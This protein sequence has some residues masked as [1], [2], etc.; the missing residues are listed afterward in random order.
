MVLAVTVWG[1]VWPSLAAAATW[2]LLS[3]S[4][5]DSFQARNLDQF[6][7]DVEQATAGQLRIVVLADPARLDGRQIKQAVAAGRA[8]AGELLFSDL[9][10]EDAAFE[11]DS[12]PFLATDYYEALRLWDASRPVL[13]RMLEA[14]GVHA[15]FAVASPPRGLFATKNI[16]KMDDLRGLRL[17]DDN[18]FTRQLAIL[19][20]AVPTRVPGS[21][22]QAFAAGEIDAAIASLPDGV[23][24]QAWD[25]V[26][27]YYD[28]GVTLPKSVVVFNR[29]AFGSLDPE[30]QRAVLNAA[31]A[32]Q[33][34]GW[35]ASA[36][37]NNDAV[38]LMQAHG[39]SIAAP[40]PQLLA[41]MRKIGARMADEWERRSGSDAQR[42]L[43]AYRM[44]R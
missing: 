29:A 10:D 24:Q 21:M 30:V 8:P 12:I 35:K 1:Y 3:P 36:A 26:D 42:I 34:R 39:M 41:D 11:A 33:N 44:Q 37:A 31:V 22:V 25:V 23:A 9:R 40:D 17:L 38:D 5:P 43:R 13:G 7:N 20:E 28:L 16:T 14:Q 2:E 19:V 6:A 18:P 15:V 27:R 32:A 4:R